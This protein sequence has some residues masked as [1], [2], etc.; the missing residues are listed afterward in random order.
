MQPTQ[1][2]YAAQTLRAV[3]ASPATP[4]TLVFPLR[5]QTQTFARIVS[6]SSSLTSTVFS[7]NQFNLSAPLI[8]RTT[9]SAN[10]ANSQIAYAL[11]NNVDSIA[12]WINLNQILFVDWRF[13]SVAMLTTDSEILAFSTNQQYLIVSLNSADNLT[14]LAIYYLEG[15]TTTSDSNVVSPILIASITNQRLQQVTGAN[16]VTVVDIVNLDQTYYLLTDSQI[17][18]FG[19]EN[20][21]VFFQDPVD[22]PNVARLF[23]SNDYLVLVY[24]NLTLQRYDVDIASTFDPSYVQN[25]Y[26][27]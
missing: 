24:N 22:A 4:Q 9:Y 18:A 26:L 15:L 10:Y 7:Y 13:A 17:I 1:L 3:A 12:V 8:Q 14:D 2:G 25:V 16:A 20:G 5:T 23:L 21:V 6:D 27:Y 11:V 19:V